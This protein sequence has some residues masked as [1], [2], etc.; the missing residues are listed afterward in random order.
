MPDFVVS[1]DNYDVS[2]KPQNSQ[3]GTMESDA[4]HEEKIDSVTQSRQVDSTMQ[5]ALN[6]KLVLARV[7]QKVKYLSSG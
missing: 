5:T 1:D 6:S 4:V 2:D 7:N 3:I